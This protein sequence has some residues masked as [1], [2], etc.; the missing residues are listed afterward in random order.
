MADEGPR[1]GTSKGSG[2]ARAAMANAGGHFS[3][4]G[5]DLAW[6]RILAPL[7]KP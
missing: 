6:L 2:A 3:P 1:L 7:R 4:A 5:L